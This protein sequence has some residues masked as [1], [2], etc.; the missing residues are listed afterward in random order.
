MT[1]VFDGV[2]PEQTLFLLKLENARDLHQALR[3]LD[4]REAGTVGCCTVAMY[5]SA[6][7]GLSAHWFQCR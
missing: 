7:I 3:A 2:T 5:L 6:T 1:L 4:F